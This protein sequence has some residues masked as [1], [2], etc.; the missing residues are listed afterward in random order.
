MLIGCV[1]DG[2]C[3]VCFVVVMFFDVG[4]VWS[5]VVVKL[6]GCCDDE[7]IGCQCV[8]DCGVVWEGCVVSKGWGF[9]DGC[10]FSYVEVVSDRGVV[11][12]WECVVDVEVCWVRV[13]CGKGCGFDV[14]FVR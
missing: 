2:D 10:V 7:V 6:W 12:Y 5:V 4:V 1:L 14:L 9:G 3:G 11:C 8:G 13:L